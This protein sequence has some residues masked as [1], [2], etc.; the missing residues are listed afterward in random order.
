MLDSCHWTKIPLPSLLLLSLQLQSLCEYPFQ[1]PLSKQPQSQKLWR[2]NMKIINLLSKTIKTFA[3]EWCLLNP[4]IVILLVVS[5]T[6]SRW[7]KY[8]SLYI[9]VWWMFLN[10]KTSNIP[11]KAVADQSEIID[12]YSFPPLFDCIYIIVYSFLCV[13]LLVVC[14]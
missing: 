6:A 9:N 13:H 3:T 1:Y 11:A 7:K 12:S 10:V 8:Q 14:S 2:T 4:S 5:W